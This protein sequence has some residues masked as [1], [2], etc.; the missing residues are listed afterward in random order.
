M[1]EAGT[2]QPRDPN[3]S[4]G[5]SVSARPPPLPT[6]P[7]YELIEEIGAG[8]MGVVYKARQIALGRVVAIKMLRGHFGKNDLARF[9]REAETAA[10]LQ[11]THIVHVYEVGSVE[12]KPYFSMEYLD[13]GTLSARGRATT[14]EGDASASRVSRPTTKDGTKRTATAADP[15]LMPA[16]EA[17]ELVRCLAQ[18]VHFAHERG[19]VHRD[20]KPANVL[21]SLDAC[22]KIADFGIAK[23]LANDADETGAAGSLITDTGAVMG[24]PSY[25]APEQARGDSRGVGPPAD[26]YALGAI[27]YELLAGRP[28]FLPSDSQMSLAARTVHEEP[29]SPAY[30]RPSTPRE[31]EAICLKCLRKAPKDRYTTAQALADDLGRFLADEPILARP[32]SRSARAIKWVRRHP[33]RIAWRLAALAAVVAIAWRVWHWD[34]YERLRTEYYAQFVTVWGETRGLD[35]L[36][37]DQV[38]HRTTSIKITRRGRRG[39]VIRGEFVNAQGYPTVPESF[40]TWLNGLQG[41]AASANPVNRATARVENTYNAAGEVVEEIGRD[42]NGHI[43]YRLQYDIGEQTSSADLTNHARR[44]KGRFFNR[45]GFLLTSP[46]GAS[47]VRIERTQSGFDHRGMLFDAA[48]QPAPN[49]DGVYGMAFERDTAGRAILVT[50]LDQ[51]GQPMANQYG[52]A[53]SVYADL[54]AWGVARRATFT[55]AAGRPMTASDG[56]ATME[57]ETDAYGNALRLTSLDA[58][59]KKVAGRANGMASVLRQIDERGHITRQWY[60]GAGDEPVESRSEGWASRTFEYDARGFCTRLVEANASGER[61][62]S[63]RFVHDDRGNELERTVFDKDDKRIARIEQTLDANGNISGEKR[64]FSTG[65]I[66]TRRQFSGERLQ[67][68]SFFDQNDKPLLLGASGSR[69]TFDYDAN[70]VLTA[71]TDWGFDAARKGYAAARCTFDSRGR[72]TE[73]RY[74]AADGTTVVAKD[75]HYA[76]LRIEYD[77]ISGQRIRESSLDADGKPVR[78]AEGFDRLEY[79]YTADGSVTAITRFGYDREQHGYAIRRSEYDAKERLAI[80]RFLD[81][82]SQPVRTTD[83]YD[84]IQYEHRTD[85]S[86]SSILQLGFDGNR[87]FTAIRI[88]RDEHGYDVERT[89]LDKDGNVVTDDDNQ[90]ATSKYE[91]DAKGRLIMKR[92]FGVDGQPTRCAAGYDRI[93]YQHRADGKLESGLEMGYDAAQMGYASV[94]V[95]W[96][97]RNAEIQRTYAAADGSPV[98]LHGVWGKRTTRDLRDT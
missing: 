36:T 71:N 46:K 30:H 51:N 55:D 90:V 12:G 86:I 94:R 98:A 22:P 39:P 67:E 3:W 93:A 64:I 78:G 1:D 62:N 18:A 23:R 16:R 53:T 68:E 2:S 44:V 25:M 41:E 17:A 74:L 33:M 5:A 49:A 47:Y 24:T 27:L 13:G 15:Q 56:Y 87:G 77:P 28:P 96:N 21:F 65:I 8:G 80:D 31:L 34:A 91:R 72:R 92:F 66:T 88:R 45:D 79:S 59:G 50:T 70:G 43:T 83:G 52:V 9:L 60:L 76:I 81:A 32:P 73:E 63:T 20:L 29:V 89:N 26:V 61:I 69:R 38:R 58:S 42:R 35:R 4:A 10:G 40:S 84:R 11:H 48:G 54:D 95:L 85:G 75:T 37:E 6:I 97:E 82:Q 19:V 14:S 57:A 7:G